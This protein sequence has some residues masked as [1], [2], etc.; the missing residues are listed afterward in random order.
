MK[1]FETEAH[2]IQNPK[3]RERYL[4][5]FGSHS[6]LT[7]NEWTLVTYGVTT[8]SAIGDKILRVATKVTEQHAGDVLFDLWQLQ[9]AVASRERFCKVLV[10]RELGVDGMDA[11]YIQEEDDDGQIVQQLYAEIDENQKDAPL[12]GLQFWLLQFTPE[13]LSTKRLAEVVFHRVDELQKTIC[14]PE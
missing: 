9:E 3:G 13:H 12:P 8:L 11:G 5:S 1:N 4:R 7:E 2:I 6:S 10:F 14:L